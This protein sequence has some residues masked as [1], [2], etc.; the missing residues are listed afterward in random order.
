MSAPPPSG[1]TWMIYGASGYTGEL[2]AREAVRRGERPILAGRSRPAIEALGHELGLATRICGL[3]DAAGL[4]AALDGVAAV[5]HCA[6]PFV[7]TAAP[8]VAACLARGAHYLDIT[9]EIAVFERHLHP[10]RGLGAPARDAGIAIVSGVG[11]DVVPTDCLAATLAAALPDAKA[12]ELAFAARGGSWSA[13]TLKT[14]IEAL[15]HAGAERREGRIVPLPAARYSREV[16]F[17]SGARL[18]VSIPW[19]D[20][21]TAWYS[22]GIPDIRVYTAMPPAAARRLR[23]LRLLLPLAGLKPVKRALQAWVARRVEGPD[24]RTRESAHM[25]IWGEVRNAAGVTVSAT[26]VT[27]EGYRFTARTAVEA[28]LRT[29]AGAVAPGAWTPSRAFGAGFL[30][31]LPEVVISSLR[32]SPG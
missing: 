13:G 29:L 17:G 16:D 31:E 1:H 11:F 21:A 27:P 22:T 10:R 30:S 14:A 24:E 18:V 19:G 9:G 2:V 32:R 7:R 12:L 25:E 26:A 23:R 3:D 8:M 15:P 6:G 20:V 4:A 28:T 5:L